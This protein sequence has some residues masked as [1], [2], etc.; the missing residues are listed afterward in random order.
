MRRLAAA[1]AMWLAR[2]ARVMERISA[3]RTKS[4]SE[5]RSTRVAIS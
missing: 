4:A 2:A 3:M 5:A 1:R